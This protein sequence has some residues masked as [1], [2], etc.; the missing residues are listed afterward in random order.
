MCLIKKHFLPRISRK[1]IKCYKVLEVSQ[2]GAF[3]T[4]YTFDKI[5]K[6]GMLT[7]K[8]KCWKGLVESV[9][10]DW[11]I[12]AFTDLEEA[13]QRKLAIRFLTWNKSFVV[14]EATI[15]PNTLYFKGKDNDICARKMIIQTDKQIKE[16][17]V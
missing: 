4:P 16:K 2:D 5:Q 15:P 17:E 3:Y 8:G 1:P 9:L 14:V 10:G 7:G 11:G 13:H 6:D 12:H